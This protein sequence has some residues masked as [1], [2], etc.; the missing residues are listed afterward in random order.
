MFHSNTKNLEHLQFHSTS[1]SMSVTQKKITHDIVF[2]TKTEVE[3]L[4]FGYIRDKSHALIPNDIQH[5][6]KFFAS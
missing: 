4:A 1:K 5:L 3:L 2:Y 6:V